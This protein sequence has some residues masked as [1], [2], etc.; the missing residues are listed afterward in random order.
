MEKLTL[1]ELIRWIESRDTTGAIRFEPLTYN[2]FAVVDAVHSKVIGDILNRI[3]SANKCSRSTAAMIYSSSWGAHQ[4]MGFN[5]YADEFPMPVGEF[6]VSQSAQEGRFLSFI[7]RNGLQ[8]FTPEIL[9]KNH[10]MRL[11]FAI[12]YN[13]SIAYEKAMLSALAHFGLP[14]AG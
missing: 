2:K 7:K 4:M 10:D 6:L 13:G 12:K 8:D 9:A 1:S 11:K 3:I 14:L 5:V